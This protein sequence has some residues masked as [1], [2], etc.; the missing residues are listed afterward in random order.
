MGHFHVIEF[1]P[2]LLLQS[3]LFSVPLALAP[4]AMSCN[5]L[6]AWALIVV[7]LRC[8]NVSTKKMI[9]LVSVRIHII[10]DMHAQ[11]HWAWHAQGV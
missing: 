3:L 7:L 4:K 9:V 8:T 2:H 1:D 10:Y 11:A 6:G 5:F